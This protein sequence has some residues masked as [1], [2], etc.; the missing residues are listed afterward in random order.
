MTAPRLTMPKVA[1]ADWK[2]PARSRVRRIRDRLREMYGRPVN[3]PHRK[4]LDSLVETVLSQATSDLN[5]DRAFNR[6]KERF[7]SWEQ[8]RIIMMFSRLPL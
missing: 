3:L 2:R 8:V 6:L 5:R 1:R 7:G 4:P